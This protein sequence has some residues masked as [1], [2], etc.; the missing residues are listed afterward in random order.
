M[1]KLSFSSAFTGQ[2][3]MNLAALC[4][5]TIACSVLFIGT[6][7]AVAAEQTSAALTVTVGTVTQAQ[8]PEAVEA[9]GAIAPW[10]EAVIGSQVS[11][12]R[13]A[14]ILVNVGDRVKRGQLLAT[15][16]ADLLGTDEVRLKASWQQAEANRQR[17]LQLKGTGG[18]S[19]QDVL[20][21]VTQAGI[22]KA[23][24]QNT[25]L[26][27]RYAKVVAP[28]DGVISA[29]S[30]TVGAV[31]STGQELFRMIRQSRLEWRGEL[32]AVQ[33]SQV[34]PGQ[35]ISLEL[36]D[37]TFAKAVVR[38]LAPS[39]DSQ[40]RLGLVYADIEPGSTAR[41]GM[42]PGGKILLSERAALVVPAASVVIRDGR[43]YVPK[44]LAGNRIGMQSVTV[45]RRRN[46]EVEIVSGIAVTDKVVVQGAGFLNDGDLVHVT[47]APAAAQE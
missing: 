8:W 39:L 40:T 43:S 12:L 36:P 7:T 34:K 9:S 47:A 21:Y 26:Q 25:L 41:A 45:G 28:D 10:E 11:G 32:T 19:E 14:E 23:L 20:Q 37:G 22:A 29:R 6:H 3:F 31:Y 46:E 15:F 30:A 33:L 5:N 44:L 17:A 1:S 27:L 24:L 4:I 35:G 2:V 13:L 38:E 42:Y 16:D 18:M